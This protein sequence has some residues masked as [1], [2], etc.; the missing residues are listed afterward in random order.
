MD[1][2]SLPPPRP[3]R[4]W[5]PP[6]LIAAVTVATFLPS[7]RGEFL[8]W[9][10]DTN[11]L[12]NQNYRGLRLENLRWMFTD[13][14][15]HYMPLTWLTLGLDYV[16]WGMDPRG[17]HATNLALHG[18]NAA[19]CFLVLK[20]LARRA[21]PDLSPSRRVAAAAAGALVFSVHPLRVESV[22]WITERRD[23]LSGAFFLLTLLAYLRM[24]DQPERSAGRRMAMALTCLAFAA[25]LLSK[26][27]AV[28]L[29]LVLLLL[30]AYPLGR[31]SRASLPALLKEKLPLFALMI[32]GLAMISF[33]AGKAGGM[34][35]RDH[36]PLIQSLARPGFALSFYV[37]KT[38][39]P[40]HL[41]PLY[42]YRPQL[43]LVHVA[44]WLILLALT[45]AAAVGWRRAPAA[46]AGWLAYGLLIS[47]ASGLVSLGSFYAADHFSYV[48]CLPFAALATALLV[49]LRRAPPAALGV[50]SAAALIALSAASARYCFV[51]RDSVSLWSRAIELEPDV[52]FSLVN[53]GRSY[54]ARREWDRALADYDRA[55]ELQQGWDA[56]WALRAEA[57]LARGDAPGAISDATVS[58]QLQPKAGKAL[59][60]RGLSLSRIG[61]PREAIADLTK[62]LEIDPNFVEAR[63]NR[64]L[65]RAKLGD[66]DGSL[67]DFD[68]AVAYDPNP[69]VYFR[70]AV[71]RGLKGDVEGAIADC[72]EAIRLK[73]D[74]YEAYVRRGAARMERGETE[75]A[76]QDFSR[77]LELAPPDWPQRRQTEEFLQRA[78]GAK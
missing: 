76:A 77:A 72:T 36:Y 64:A 32:A 61:K 74:F 38:L 14:F 78:R 50:A 52:Y 3:E 33:T 7:F 67:A 19:L 54:A 75:R 65:E 9:D 22:A 26:A 23:V 5:L 34:S 63:V 41:S 66:L 12:F 17:Y 35:D 46:L 48:A 45:A 42:W 57:R 6:L 10:D 16:L 28:T 44:G 70:R 31:L 49:S 59:L 69:Y 55:L 40:I 1:S 58:L 30:D 56:P 43:G 2:T 15:G 37:G 20:S 53:R 13:V 73:P 47:P 39:L 11:F 18:L 60:T 21:V 8:L 4:R 25:M 68:A 51:W 27:M 62:A 71:P 29:P 24:I